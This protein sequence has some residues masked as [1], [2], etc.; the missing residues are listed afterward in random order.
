MGLG[1]KAVLTVDSND[2]GTMDVTKLEAV[3]EQAKAEGLIPFAIVGTAGTTDHGA[4]DELNFIAD[5]AEKH[6]MWMHVDSAYGG[7]LVLSSH[8]ERL[9]GVERADSVTVDFHKMFFQTISC[10][11][12]LLKD[13][14]RFK[15]LLHHADYLN[16]EHDTLPNL[17]DKSMSTTKR[18]DA[19]KVYMTMQSVGPKA[20]GDMV[21]HLVEQT[22][23]VA[24]LVDSHPSF[25]LLTQPSLS[26]VLF[27]AVN[28]QASDLDKLNQVLRMEALTRGVAVLGETIVDGKTALK[29]TIL[30]PCL[31]M[32]D[33]NTLLTKIEDLAAELA[34]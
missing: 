13:K 16:R 10:S 34:K 30:N 9:S 21:D 4:I 3:I 15:Y 31:Q 7:A 12:V 5:V 19:L 1:E 27:R 25:E 33:F 11:A 17:V 2:N 8:K 29:F 32:S 26:T 14:S 23:Q 24:Q 18:F 22:Q 20:L 6:E 28:S